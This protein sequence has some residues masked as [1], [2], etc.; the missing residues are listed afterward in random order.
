MLDAALDVHL[1]PFRLD[2]ELTVDDGEV[3]ALLGPNGAGK[4]TALRAIAGLQPLDGGRLVLDGAVLD[5]PAADT[6][7]PT[8]RRPIGVVF[9]DYLLFPHLT[10]LD[11]VAFGPRAT[12]TRRPQAREAAMRRLTEVDAVQFAL[13]RPRRLSGGQAQRIALARAL[14]AD[15]DL[16][17]LDEPL[18]AVDVEIAPALRSLLRSVLADRLALIVTH[19]VIDALVLA[20]RVVVLEGGRVVEQGPTRE[21]LTR[22]RSA[23]AARLAGLNLVSGTATAN[24][25][26]AEDGFELTGVTDSTVL[27]TAAVAVFTPAAVA[28]YMD[29]PKGSPRNVIQDRVAALEPNGTLVRV[30]GVAG[31]AADITPVAVVELGLHAGAGVWFV[32]K[33]AE[34][35][36]YPVNGSR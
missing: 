35:A 8:A 22:P 29:P 1:G 13:R 30:R 32:V 15:P 5:D 4:T 33:A 31:L 2:I 9:Q 20:D 3:V 6:F 17:L 25:L 24:G 10:A 27:G 36:V 21:V 28:V 23:F 26:R 7:V 19:Q 18:S 34:V 14:A 11:N 16:L 12:G